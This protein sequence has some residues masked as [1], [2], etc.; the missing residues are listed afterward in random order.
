L[1]TLR[2][3]GPRRGKRFPTSASFRNGALLIRDGVIAAVGARSKVETL[4][5]ARAAE[6]V[7]VARTRGAAGIC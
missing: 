3:R 4:P 2:G 6:K 7:D 5:E 1:L